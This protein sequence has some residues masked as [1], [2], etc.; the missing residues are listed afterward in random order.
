MDTILIPGSGAI[1]TTG[2]KDD[3]RCFGACGINIY[4]E[5]VGGSNAFQIEVIY[6]LEGSPQLSTGTNNIPIP[7]NKPKQVIGST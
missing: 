4:Y 3:T 5:G 1:R 2:Y 7:S 6:H